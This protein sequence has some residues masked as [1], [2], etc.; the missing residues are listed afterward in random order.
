MLLE[1]RL[2]GA[3]TVDFCVQL[4][5]SAVRANPQHD[6][7]LGV[8]SPKPPQLFCSMDKTVDLELLWHQY[9]EQRESGAELAV[10]AHATQQA[11]CGDSG[12]VCKSA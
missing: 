3:V 1:C 5:L 11:T 9:S 4:S 12:V 8:S 7:E 10:L 2:S 6:E